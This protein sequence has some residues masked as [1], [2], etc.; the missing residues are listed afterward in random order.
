MLVVQPR[1]SHHSQEKLGSIGCWPSVCHRQHIG[2]I[3]SPFFRA[4]FV[5]EVASPDGLPTSAV[6]AGTTTL[7]HESLDNSVE[8]GVVVVALF[9]QFYEILAGLGA[10]FQEQVQADVPKRCIQYHLTLLLGYLE[11]LLDV[12]VF[13]TYLLIHDISH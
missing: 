3:E 10:L 8:Y 2:P 5:F 9:G 11:L 12:V 4:E 7:V 6:A 1:A 13:L